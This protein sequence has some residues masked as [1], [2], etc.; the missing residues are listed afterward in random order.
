MYNFLFFGEYGV[1]KT[2]LGKQLT[3]TTYEPKEDFYQPDSFEVK[4]TLDELPFEANLMKVAYGGRGGSF[5]KHQHTKTAHGFIL[6]YSI[7]N[8]ESFDQLLYD[9]VQI[10]SIRKGNFPCIILANKADLY[11]TRVVSTEEGQKLADKFK[12]VFF[13]TSATDRKNVD[14]SF[15]ELVRQTRKFKF[16]AMEAA[17]KKKKM[18]LARFASPLKKKLECSI[19]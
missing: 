18:T 12:A 17:V 13:E 9:Y 11:E 19:Q 14:E 1:G 2:T 3:T 4:G 5:M 15:H 6:V 7:D 10:L 16:I 8:R